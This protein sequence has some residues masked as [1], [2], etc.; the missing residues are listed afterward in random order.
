MSAPST[1]TSSPYDERTELEPLPVG[2][3]R[4]QT[5]LD[6]VVDWVESVPGPRRSSTFHA[7]YGGR[8]ASCDGKVNRGEE[9]QYGL[10][11]QIEHTECPDPL[12]IPVQ[13]VCA[14]CYL[15]LPVTGICGVCE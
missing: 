3:A 8:C 10:D 5:G 11:D 12:T 6:V 13:G 15:V 9:V 4:K 1:Y 14:G 7:R 2:E